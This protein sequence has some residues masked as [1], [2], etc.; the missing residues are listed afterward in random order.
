[1]RPVLACINVSFIPQKIFKERSI[2]ASL[3]KSEG[4]ASESNVAG[5]RHTQTHEIIMYPGTS[6]GNKC[7]HS[8]RFGVRRS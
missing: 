4:Q 2:A 7:L 3:S 5:D 6:V 8:G 1:M